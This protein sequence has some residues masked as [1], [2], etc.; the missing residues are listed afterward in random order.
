MPAAGKAG[1]YRVSCCFIGCL[2]TSFYVA[3][4]S[5]DETMGTFMNALADLRLLHDFFGLISGPAVFAPVEVAESFM[6][7]CEA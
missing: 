3:A 4:K 1:G 6:M 7:C 5:L 2:V